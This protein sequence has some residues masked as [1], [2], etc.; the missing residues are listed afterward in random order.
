VFLDEDD[1]HLHLLIAL[2]LSPLPAGIGL[3]SLKGP[4]LS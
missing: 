1:L 3:E 2:N 4:F